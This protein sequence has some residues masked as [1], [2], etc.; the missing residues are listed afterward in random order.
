M[1]PKFWPQIPNIYKIIAF[2]YIYIYI[3]IHTYIYQKTLINQLHCRQSNWCCI[4]FFQGNFEKFHINHSR[5]KYNHKSTNDKTLFNLK[6]FHYN[7]L[8]LL[9]L[10]HAKYYK[11]TVQKVLIIPTYIK[12]IILNY[13]T[14]RYRLYVKIKNLKYH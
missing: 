3:Y 7:V 5:W 6:L 14:I 1:R 4:I 9:Q 13:Y 10:N 2:I 12:L 11:I 8:L